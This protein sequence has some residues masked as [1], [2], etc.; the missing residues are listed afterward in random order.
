MRTFVV[1]KAFFESDGVDGFY[2]RN[3]VDGRLGVRVQPSV[4]LRY[5]SSTL[6]ILKDLGNTNSISPRDQVS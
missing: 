5:S 2:V 6:I 4:S 1:G 3:G